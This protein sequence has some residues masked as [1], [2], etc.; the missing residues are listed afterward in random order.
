[1]TDIDNP[2]EADETAPLL[3]PKATNV[4]PP[5]APPDSVPV[6][7]SDDQDT[8]TTDSPSEPT[9]AAAE[10]PEDV[11]EQFWNAEK[12]EIATDKLMQS[13]RDLRA[14]MDSGKHKVPKDGNYTFDAL[15]EVPQDDEALAAFTEIARDEGLSQSAAE[16]LVGLYMEQQG[17][18]GEEQKYQR[19]EEMARLGRN[20]DKIVASTDAWLSKMQGS[21][22]I[23]E[24]ELEAM[25]DAST[26]ADV[27]LALNKIRRSYNELDVPSFVNPQS[28]APDMVTITSMMAD[29]KYGNDRDYT[30]KV[31]RMVYEMNGESYPG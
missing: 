22:V 12:G 8:V 23:S 14:K 13:Y 30:R 28:D 11:P 7:A 4:E 24:R 29:S 27:V 9:D 3:T 21:G 31:E 18:V 25:A 16:R 5:K 26:S 19:S 2:P 6:F 10:R 15:S 17:I 1:M 20:G